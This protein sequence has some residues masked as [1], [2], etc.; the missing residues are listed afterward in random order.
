[1]SKRLPKWPI[2]CA[3]RE[4]I[5]PLRGS[6]RI[7]RAQVAEG[8]VLLCQAQFSS[9]IYLQHWRFKKNHPYQI[10][11]R[12]HLFALLPPFSYLIIAEFNLLPAGSFLPTN[13]GNLAF[14]GNQVIDKY[15]E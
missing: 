1:M 8:G 13:S 12:P 7:N 10:Q 14:Q 11:H 2:K 5:V 3:D 9:R 4:L 15:P 6:S